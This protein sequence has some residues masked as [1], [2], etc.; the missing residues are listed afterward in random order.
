M[1]AGGWEEEGVE[2]FSFWGDGNVLELNSREGC[3]NYEYATQMYTLK[4]I[5]MMN[6][7]LCGFYLN[8]K[9]KKKERE[10]AEEMFKMFVQMVA[11][12]WL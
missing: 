12:W 10:E 7:V 9:L 1:V 4:R 5:K 3:T 11:P 6:F 2:K 8:Q